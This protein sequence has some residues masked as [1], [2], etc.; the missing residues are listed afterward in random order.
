MPRLYSEA[1]A[2]RPAVPYTP[3]A[4]SQKEQ[5]GYIITLTHFEEEN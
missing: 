5:N 3:Y 1:M 4:A 2:M